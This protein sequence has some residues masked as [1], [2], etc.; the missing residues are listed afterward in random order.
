LDD[1]LLLGISFLGKSTLEFE[2]LGSQVLAS[3]SS[4]VSN[5]SSWL[6]LFDHSSSDCSG[7]FSVSSASHDLTSVDSNSSCKNSFLG[8]SLLD[9]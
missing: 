5:D 1:T 3:S 9:L 8:W 6:N 2:N 4:N 7:N